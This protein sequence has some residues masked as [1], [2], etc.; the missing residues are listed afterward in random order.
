MNFQCPTPKA[1]RV[2]AVSCAIGKISLIPIVQ[3]MLHRALLYHHYH[4]L[5]VIVD[6]W[7]DLPR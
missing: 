5:Y 1:L 4:G 2:D 3:V 6:I 7:T